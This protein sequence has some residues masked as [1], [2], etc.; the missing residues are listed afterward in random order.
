M[1]LSKFIL[2][3]VFV[4]AVIVGCA[5][6]SEEVK[7]MAAD[8]YS[9]SS[10]PKPKPP[11]GFNSDG[12]SYFPDGDWVECCVIHDL[13]YWKGGTKEERKNADAMLNKCVADKGHPR[14]AGLMYYGVR[15]GGVWWLPTPF[16]W[17]FGWPYPQSGPPGKPY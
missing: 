16:R 6:T 14:T 3:M 4:M 12:C 2:C 13:A 10:I 8:L 1:Q 15:L 11:Y 7:K 5:G 17:G 9:K